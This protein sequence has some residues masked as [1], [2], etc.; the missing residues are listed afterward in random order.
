MIVSNVKTVFP[1]RSEKTI[2]DIVLECDGVLSEFLRGQ[3]LVML[4]LSIIYACGLWLAGIEYAFLIGFAAGLISIV[5]YLGSIV[6][7][8]VA[9]VVAFFQYHD[10]LHIIYVAVIFGAGQAIEGMLL[11]PLLVGDRI[12]LH[13]VAVIFAVMAGGQLFGFTGILLALP[14]AAVCL[15]LLRFAFERYKSSELYSQ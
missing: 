9:G 6:G 12:G 7:I 8:G 4:F 1:V 13:P 15:V 2:T 3:L 11:S 5:P 10:L 14:I